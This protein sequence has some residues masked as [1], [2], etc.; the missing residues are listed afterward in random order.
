MHAEAKS[1]DAVS[2][3]TLDGTALA[4]L[5]VTVVLA[6]AGARLLAT[7]GRGAIT[8]GVL[9]LI[10][11]LAAEAVALGSGTWG[12]DVE[13]NLDMSSRLGLGVLGGILAA[14]FHGLLTML[15]DWIGITGLLAPGLDAHL[16]AADWGV[17]LL[18]GVAWANRYQSKP[19]FRRILSEGITTAAGGGL[20][21]HRG[22]G[23]SISMPMQNAPDVLAGL[24]RP[25]KR[26]QKR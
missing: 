15:A 19:L 12:P 18:H 23:K 14:V 3:G 7:G 9:L 13:G 10:G 5:A 6:L 17:R 2:A 1:T 4:L 21:Q 16:T 8:G 25:S 24:P 22:I 11:A 20:R 26:N